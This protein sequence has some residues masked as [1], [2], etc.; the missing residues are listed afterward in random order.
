M[1]NVLLIINPRAG[2]AKVKASLFDIV[3][4][5][6][7]HGM[8]VTV[9]VTKYGGHARDIAKYIT[10]EFDMVVCVG[11]DG[12]LN[13]V[14]AGM[15][16]SGKNIPIGYIPAGSTNDFGTTLKLSKDLKKA[17]LDICN[18]IE[19]TIDI[20]RFG[21][22]YFSYVASF[23]AFTRT[24]YATPQNIKNSLGHLAYVLQGIQD[25][26]SIRAEHM[27]ITDGCGNTYEDDY[28]FG[29]IANST[30]VG[31]VISFKETLVSMND[32][33]FEMLLIKKPKNLADLNKCITALLSQNYNCNS[34][35]FATVNSCSVKCNNPVT[36]SLDG[37]RADTDG[38][39]DIV[40]IKNAVKMILP[41]SLEDNALLS[42][43]TTE[44][45]G[46]ND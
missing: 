5:F 25:L 6:T 26:P 17:A 31:G 28:I 41:S 19:R 10:T 30:S 8:R 24:S 21:D 23:G 18:G 4:T 34:I 45:C 39:I 14:I 2:R 38:N 11:G 20:G 7:E 43:A 32:G 40:N 46:C 44:D 37:E 33:R 29:A 12:T 22:R 13:E 16:E 27:V 9:E 1:K 15:I 3:D 36:W 35:I 42:S